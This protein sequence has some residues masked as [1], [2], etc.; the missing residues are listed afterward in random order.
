M[1]NQLLLM[2]AGNSSHYVGK[3]W[4]ANFV[5]HYLELQT[6]LSR[7]Y[8][9]QWAKYE[10]YKFISDW[11]QFVQAVKAKYS[12]VNN[13]IYNFDKIGFVMGI[14]SSTIVVT[15]AETRDKAKLAQPGNREWATVIQGICAGGWTVPPF[16]ILAGKYH[17]ASWYTE[18]SLPKD[19]VIALSDNSWTTNEL[20][21]E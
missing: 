20:A 21:V 4:A 3:N 19:W 14:I 1:A 13:N 7:K 9:Y 2:C 17:L 8:D 18:T 11:L 15:G 10:D 16:I 5:K 12:I 6:H